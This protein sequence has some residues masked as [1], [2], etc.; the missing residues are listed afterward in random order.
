MTRRIDGWFESLAG[1]LMTD[2]L[3]IEEMDLNSGTGVSWGK[4]GNRR[5]LS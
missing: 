4:F 1:D 5:L 2:R 3:A